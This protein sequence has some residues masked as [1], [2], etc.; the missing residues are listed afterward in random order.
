VCIISVVDGTLGR[1]QD[2]V[3][4]GL[5]RFAEDNLILV[6]ALVGGSVEVG[7]TQFVR[8]LD[9]RDGHSLR[10]ARSPASSAGASRRSRVARFSRRYCQY[11]GIALGLVLWS[12]H[13]F[14]DTA[15]GALVL[16]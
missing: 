7:H 1:E 16:P 12:C 5:D 4:P 10:R 2:L 11:P 13:G 9:D 6:L 3:V 15:Y 8:A 14:D